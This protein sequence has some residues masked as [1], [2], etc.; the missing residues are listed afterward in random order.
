MTEL[1]DRERV[2]DLTCDYAYIRGFFRGRISLIRG[3]LKEGC[4]TRSIKEC[5]DA[6]EWLDKLEQE[7]D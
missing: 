2:L 1:T 6:L 7:K 3:L 5:D 4:G